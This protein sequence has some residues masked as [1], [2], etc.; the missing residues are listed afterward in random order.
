MTCLKC[1]SIDFKKSGKTKLGYQ[2]YQC[3]KCKKYWSNSP[4]KGRPTKG[5]TAMTDA[6][7]ARNYRARKKDLNNSCTSQ[8]NKL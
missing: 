3:N 4:H 1:G 7:R 6:E 8:K 5:L 2:R